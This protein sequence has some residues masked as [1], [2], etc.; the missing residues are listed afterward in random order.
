MVQAQAPQGHKGTTT[1]ARTRRNAQ[2]TQGVQAPTIVPAHARAA[3]HQ[4]E[5][6]Q[7]EAVANAVAQAQQS[8]AGYR[9]FEVAMEGVAV[10]LWCL[11]GV[12]SMLGAGYLVTN[13]SHEHSL[14][15]TA[16][17]HSTT[18]AHSTDLVPSFLTVPNPTP[19]V[20]CEV[21][22]ADTVLEPAWL[23]A[24]VDDIWLTPL[25]TDIGDISTAEW[26]QNLKDAEIATVLQ[27]GKPARAA[28]SLPG[29][30][31]YSAESVRQRSALMNHIRASMDVVLG[32]APGGAIEIAAATT[33]QFPRELLMAELSDQQQRA[34][35]F[36]IFMHDGRGNT[37]R[38]RDAM[39]EHCKLLWEIHTQSPERWEKAY[40]STH[41]WLLTKHSI[42]GTTMSTYI[43]LVMPDVVRRSI[44]TI[45]RHALSKHFSETDGAFFALDHR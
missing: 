41:R 24:L 11:G 40:S 34:L 22:V 31:Y 10:A 35:Q 45:T 20:Q 5:E 6:R 28:R 33:E 9:V 38:Q 18:A 14:D 37:R 2:R 44:T 4:Q 16:V 30:R 19:V 29:H 12:L 36:H 15:G 3:Q 42:G 17:A 13:M 39:R 32:V 26:V 21:V 25:G 7:R 1:A 27:N 43:D 8:G 23:N